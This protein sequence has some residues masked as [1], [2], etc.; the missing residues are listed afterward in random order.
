MLSQQCLSQL[1]DVAA[2]LD[3]ET[4]TLNNGA[5][6][7][8]I[9]M[10]TWHHGPRD[11]I[12]GALKFSL[13]NGYRHIDCARVYLNEQEVGNVLQDA[14]ANKTVRRED[15]FIVGKLWGNDHHPDDVESGCR[16]SLSDLKID[17]FDAFLVH[18]PT[19]FVKDGDNLWPKDEEGHF[20]YNDDLELIDTWKAM[21]K[22]VIKGLCKSIGM[23]NYNSRQIKEILDQCF[24]KP[25]MLQVECNP[26]FNNDS[27]WR[28]CRSHGIQMVAYSPFGSPDLPWGEKMPHI[29]V[30]PVLKKIGEKHQRSTANVVLRWLLQRGLIAIPKSVIDHELAENLRVF[31]EGFELDS[32][33]MEAIFKLNTNKRKLIPLNKLKSGETVYR[34]GKSRHFPYNF[35]EPE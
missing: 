26:R 3:M 13:E 31:E 35:V 18:F 29:L 24:I 33:D 4:V 11:E 34:D 5:Q 1:I 28:F 32:E 8:T 22:L 2:L 20:K 7:P 27:L 12:M 25:S 23:S 6:M 17:Y 16:K 30:D 9:G 14:I 21:E 15:L 10:G 19:G